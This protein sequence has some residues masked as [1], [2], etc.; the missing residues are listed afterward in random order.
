VAAQALLFVWTL[1][2]PEAIYWLA[3]DPAA[4]AAGEV[5]RVVTFLFIIPM[6]IQHSALGLL[7][8]FFYLYFQYI[9]GVAL[10]DEW[11]S[12]AFTLFYLTGA[13]STIAAAFLV[14]GDAIGAFYLN[15]TIFLAFA[16][17]HPNFQV[18]LFFILPIKVK[19]IAWVAWARI[20]W[21]FAEAPMLWKFAIL[22]SLSNYFLFFGRQ[23]WEQVQNLLEHWRHKRRFKDWPG[24]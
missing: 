10:E 21:G 9:C 11:G 13:L 16:A 18:L 15:E 5:W 17:V 8:V 1:Q 23:H 24:S 19:W 3:L 2:T 22:L 7:L 12:F 4:V 6:Q 20:L 14:G